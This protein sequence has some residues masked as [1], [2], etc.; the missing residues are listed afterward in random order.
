MSGALSHLRVVEIADGIAGPYCG[1]LLATY[2]AQVIKI[3][4]PA[5][6]DSTRS[7]GPFAG[8]P[9][10]ETSIPFLFLNTAKE[11]VSVD[12]ERPTGQSLARQLAL[13]ADIVVENFPPGRL[14]GT[15]LAYHELAAERPDL[16]MVSITPFGQDGPYRDFLG[17]E[18]V[19]YAT[20]GGMHLTGDP[21]REPLLGGLQV[22]HC[23][24]GMAGYIGALAAVF[25]RDQGQKGRHVDVSIQE[26]ML[27]NVEIA[28]IENLHLGQV[29][30]RKGDRHTLVPWELFPCRDGWA[31]V[32]G[33][34]IRNWL[35][36]VDIFEEP[37]LRDEKYRHV[38]GRMAHRAEV[39]E[40]MQPWLDTHDRAEILAEGRRRGL[41]FGILNRP[42]EVLEHPQH[43]AREFFR[44]LDHPI[45]GEHVVAG[46]P[47]RIEGAP[48]THGR[49]PLLAEHTEKVLSE[50][51]DMTD[52][53]IRNLAAEG[54]ISVAP[55]VS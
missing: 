17:D 33:G 54:V 45:V 34:P 3:E 22:A 15:G 20:G 4:P 49:A 2:G 53:E 32:V 7:R 47:F 11:S 52:A 26:A 10:T 40:L 14:E 5:G 30:K 31:A 18:V 38:G 48:A 25:G 13:T 24:G 9:G 23:S 44:H 51:L 29:A 39:E 27:D 37:R 19:S 35:G 28:L 42:E 55:E 6:G 36:A 41:A 12:I 1:K 50:E 43:R 46:E 16:V 8:E 21:D